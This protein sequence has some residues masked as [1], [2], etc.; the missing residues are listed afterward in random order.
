MIVLRLDVGDVEESVAA[1][2]EVDESRL[3]SRLEVDD[4]S[5]INVAGVTFVAGTLDIQLLED[6][7]L[8]DGDP[9]FLGLQDIDQHFFFHAVSFQG[10]RTR[11]FR[12]ELVFGYRTNPGIEP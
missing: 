6:A 7:V 1:H 3:D 12:V 9:A 2:G 11:R 4:L 8:D 10:K 5:L